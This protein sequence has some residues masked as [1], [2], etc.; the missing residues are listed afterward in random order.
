MGAH[1][2]ELVSPQYL[3]HALFLFLFLFATD[4]DRGHLRIAP[5]VEDA[6]LVDTLDRAG[7][8][9]PFLG[10]VFP[11]EVFHRVIYQRNAGIAALLGTPVDESVFADVE[12]TRAGAT[13]PFVRL[14]FGDA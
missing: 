10:F 14:A 12:V 2:K 1:S 6:D 9:A 11:F 7:G 8:R 5:V 13:T 4:L 3:A